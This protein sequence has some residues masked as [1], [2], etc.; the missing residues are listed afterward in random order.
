VQWQILDGLHSA[1]IWQIP[2]DLTDPAFP[3]KPVNQVARVQKLD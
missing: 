1:A 3:E 2:G